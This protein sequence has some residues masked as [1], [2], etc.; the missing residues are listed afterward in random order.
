MP[1]EENKAEETSRARDYR[2]VVRLFGALIVII[3]LF[4]LRPFY[5]E[6]A[7]LGKILIVL[8]AMVFSR[9]P[10][11]PGKWWHIGLTREWRTGKDWLLS[12]VGAVLAVAGLLLTTPHHLTVG[13]AVS[14][15][16]GIF[17]LAIG[18]TLVVGRVQRRQAPSE[19]GGSEQ[20][21]K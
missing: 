10:R 6:N 21:R 17:A 19:N 3:A 15:W 13:P 11:A 8:A 20:V 7:R 5:T 2:L 18:A 12:G 14:Y 4:W 16:S 9:V 1:D